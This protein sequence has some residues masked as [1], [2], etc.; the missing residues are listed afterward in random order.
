MEGIGCEAWCQDLDLDRDR[1]CMYIC[2][3]ATDQS[4]LC[5]VHLYD[6]A[7]SSFSLVQGKRASITSLRTL[8]LPLDITKT[9]HQAHAAQAK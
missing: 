6:A 9:A 3:S 2:M 1:T 8:H 4:M 7:L 5:Q